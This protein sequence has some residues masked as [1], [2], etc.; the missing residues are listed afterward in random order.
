MALLE[1]AEQGEQQPGGERMSL[2]ARQETRTHSAAAS[3]GLLPHEQQTNDTALAANDK[4]LIPVHNNSSAGGLSG[5]AIARL[6]SKVR[7]CERL[8]VCAGRKGEGGRERDKR[9]R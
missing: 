5:V 2:Q 6:M 7:C 1:P 9:E 4:A 3:D 8:N